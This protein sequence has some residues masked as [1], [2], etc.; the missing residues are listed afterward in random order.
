MT[1]EELHDRAYLLA[2]QRLEQRKQKLF[3]D[4]N[5]E[6][7]LEDAIPELLELQVLSQNESDSESYDW[8]LID[9]INHKYHN[10]VVFFGD[11]EVQNQGTTKIT[12][13]I[14]QGTQDREENALIFLENLSKVYHS[15][16]NKNYGVAFG[17]GFSSTDD[18]NASFDTSNQ[19]DAEISTL[20]NRRQRYNSQSGFDEIE[21]LDP[22]E[23]GDS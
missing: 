13:N 16:K 15:K 3:F 19:T 10:I 1:F 6:F 2:Q 8:K 12:R 9:K 7:V 21:S 14:F 4:S 22:I 20:N 11:D 17:Q 5:D 18:L 23:E